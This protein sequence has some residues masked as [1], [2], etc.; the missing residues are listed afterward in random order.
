MSR[1][2][3]VAENISE[4]ERANGLNKLK[5]ITGL[6]L[7]EIKERIMDKF[8]LANYLLFQPDHK[9]KVKQLRQWYSLVEAKKFKIR[10]YEI[11]DDDDFVA[12]E[13]TDPYE[14]DLVVLQE[15][16]NEKF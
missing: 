1:V 9:E 6:N 8:P 3:F 5:D 13:E 15:I 16:I 11:N 4:V 14:I 10:M 7:V 2:V 12:M